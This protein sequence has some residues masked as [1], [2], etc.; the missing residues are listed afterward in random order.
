MTLEAA[1]GK[2]PVNHVG[3][4]YNLVASRIAASLATEI[5]GLAD[6]SCTMVSQIGRPID[7]PH[8]VDVALFPGGPRA[9]VEEV[10]RAELARFA[11]L[12]DELLA[13]RMPTW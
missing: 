3:K 5:A 12:R 7:D 10:V 1:A 2:N 8:V 4:L 13:E 11:S 9:V 6:A